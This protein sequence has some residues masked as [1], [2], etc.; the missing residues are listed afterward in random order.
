[1]LGEKYMLIAHYMCEFKVFRTHFNFH[2]CNVRINLFSPITCAKA[3]IFPL[4][5]CDLLMLC[6]KCV[7]GSANSVIIVR[8]FHI[9]AKCVIVS[10]KLQYMCEM[11]NCKCKIFIYHYKNL[12]ND[13][14][15][16]TR[17]LEAV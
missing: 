15:K 7:V 9:C 3:L 12:G 8:N 6:A 1:M 17:R 2:T 13:S 10:A 14:V 11:C 16:R 4:V 5:M